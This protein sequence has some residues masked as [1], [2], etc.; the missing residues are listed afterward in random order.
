M[1]IKKRWILALV[2]AALLV[3]VVTDLSTTRK[4]DIRDFDPD[5]VARL[6]NAMWRSYYAREPVRMFFQ[7]AE[8]LRSQYHFTYLKSNLVAYHA[9]KAAFVFK[10][11]ASRADYVQALPDLVRYYS[12]LHDIST[13]PFDV[14]RAA[15][16]ELEWWIVHRQRDQYKPG[17]LDRAVAVAAAEFYGVSADKLL[18]Y[19]RFRAE[20]MVIRDE[21]ANEGGVTEE[22]WTKMES[23]LDNS[24][25]SL[26]Q[27]LHK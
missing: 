11:G 21:K 4:V 9:A 17:D 3:W 25:R 26:W 19:G 12:Y 15:D 5:E 23:L 1:K 24:W 16:L 8:L 10:K 20:A 13:T 6:D 27:N 2:M 7:L 22:D 18:E 14:K